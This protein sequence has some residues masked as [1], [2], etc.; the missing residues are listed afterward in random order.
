MSVFTKLAGATALSF[1]LAAGAHAEVK[2]E[3][4]WVRATVPQQNGT[5]AFMKLTADTDTKL[6]AA[7]SP[8]AKFVEVHEMAMENNIMKMREVPAVALPAGQTVELRPGSY[9][10][11][12]IDLHGQV[13]VGDEVPLTLTFEDAN[14]TRT[15]QQ[16]NAPVRP[17]ASGPDGGHGH[18][19]GHGHGHGAPK[20]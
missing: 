19:H 7:D 17:L 6:V 2:I 5:G 13:K 20:H 9:H 8:V 10:I 3:N 4:P 16:V 12:L 14:G 18:S 15:T 1:L 11:M